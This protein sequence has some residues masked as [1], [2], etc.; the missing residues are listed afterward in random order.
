MSDSSD[1][2]VVAPAEVPAVVPAVS[3]KPAASALWQERIGAFAKTI[4]KPFEEVSKALVDL[5]GAPDDESVMSL[6]DPEC[7]GN[8]LLIGRINSALPGIP[9]VKLNKAIK[10]L[11]AAAKPAS[12]AP[13]AAKP[14][15]APMGMSLITLPE[16][17][18]DE[19]FLE[20]LRVGGVAKMSATDV[21]AA[22]RVMLAKQIGVYD[23]PEQ[24]GEMME[25]HAEELDEP[26][27]ESFYALQKQ[28]GE[29][30]YG[31]ILQAMG[32]PG[33]FVS[34][35]RK[36]KLLSRMDN[37]WSLLAGFQGRLDAW[38]KQWQDK[39]INPAAM[40]AG[41]SAMLS[42]G[43]AGGMPGM[44]DH[45][46]VAPVIDAAASV[47]DVFNKMFAG[48]GIPVARAMAQDSLRI[49]QLLENP[50]LPAAVGCTTRDEMLKKLGAAVSADYV[51][52]EKDLV[53]YVLA[54]MKLAAGE[55]ATEQQPLYLMALQ[56]RGMN[57]PWERLQSLKAAAKPAKKGPNGGDTDADGRPFQRY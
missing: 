41:F 13:A 1:S 7:C 37:M 19:G 31:E 55:V 25:R 29:R 18:S 6:A 57:I 43:M 49:K 5:V 56:N 26:V 14:A 2:N 32:V 11:R 16:P 44:M 34:E 22:L 40:M 47:I 53:T 38:Q 21:N 36:K 42:G 24:L 46:D 4:S 48:T 35:S 39:M 52:L 12:P 54:V 17:P 23:L 45:P 9:V 33:H 15:A 30:R 27:G 20:A 10:D 8:E 51:R 50:G 3:D 28:I